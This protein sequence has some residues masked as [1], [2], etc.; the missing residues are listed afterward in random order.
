MYHYCVKGDS[1]T[2]GT[3][4]QC[5]IIICYQSL[6]QNTVKPAYNG[7]LK[8]LN[9]FQFKTGFHLTPVL[10]ARQKKVLNGVYYLWSESQDWNLC[11]L[12]STDFQFYLFIPISIF[13]FDRLCGLVVSVAHYKHRGPG[14][15]SRALLSI[16]LRE[17]GLE[18]GPLSL[19]IG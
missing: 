9:I 10:P 4:Q 8:E 11:T 2:H 13:P 16:F 15:D 1:Q 6:Y 5:E 7:N 3:C 12:H 14:F 17:L 18:R 19:V